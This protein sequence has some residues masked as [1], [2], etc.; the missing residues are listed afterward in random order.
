MTASNTPGDA[1]LTAG[2]V[3]QPKGPLG[4]QGRWVRIALA[5]SLAINLA[6]AGI[7]AG[8]ML[9]DGGP[10]QNKMMSGDLGFG[11]FTEAL[12][13]EDRIELRGAF[14]AAA[15]EMRDT[16]RAMRADFSDLLAQL[17]AVPFDP[18]ALRTS[19]ARQNTRNSDRLQLGQRLIFDLLVGMDDASRKAFA[20]RLEENLARGPK[21]HDGPDKP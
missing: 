18:A 13:K 17:R 1:T 3:P 2:P 14:L 5:V 11:P 20:G 12:S 9:R 7:I 8:A 16:R 19:F 15:P 6:V 21:R 10:M 4:S